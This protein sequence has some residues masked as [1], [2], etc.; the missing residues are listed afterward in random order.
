MPL[1]PDTELGPYRIVEAIGAGGRVEVYRARDT[2]LER[3]V[4]IKILPWYANY[5]AVTGRYGGAIEQIRLAAELDPLSR[6]INS[7][8]GGSLGYAGRYEE[9]AEQIRKTL[10][11]DPSWALGHMRLGRNYELRGLFSEAIP[12]YEKAVELDDT[13]YGL[14]N[15]GHAYA[16]SGR[17]DEAHAVLERL[18][19]LANSRYVAPIERAYVY[20]GLG[21]LDNCFEWLEKACDERSGNLLFARL[22]PIGKDIEHDPRFSDLIRR[23]GLEE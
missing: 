22:W 18:E 10:E 16:K 17:V 1:S 15:V 8:H 21:D 3:D 23:I 4:A 5:L 20:A 9:G 13:P 14:G 6:I 7:N 19:E 11:L 2:R 12:H